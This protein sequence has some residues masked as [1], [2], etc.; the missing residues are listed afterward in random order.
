MY[1]YQQPSNSKASN[2][3]SNNKAS[4]NQGSNSNLWCNHHYTC[5]LEWIMVQPLSTSPVKREPNAPIAVSTAKIYSARL[6]GAWHGVGVYAYR[7]HYLHCSL[8]HS[9]LMVAKTLSSFASSAI[10]LRVPSRLTAAD[11]HAISNL[12]LTCLVSQ[13]LMSFSVFLKMKR[14]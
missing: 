7:L 12:C 8:F 13:I 11:M 4:N 1:G 6:W 3:V 14:I 10:R 9:V 5:P 2:K